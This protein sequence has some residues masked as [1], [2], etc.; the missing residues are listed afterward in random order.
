M[1]TALGMGF[2]VI[3]FLVLHSIVRKQVEGTHRLA[4]YTGKVA[5]VAVSGLQSIRTIKSTGLESDF[6]ARWAGHDS[7]G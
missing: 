4:Y 1:L 6:F 7:P 3:N 5:G 2:A